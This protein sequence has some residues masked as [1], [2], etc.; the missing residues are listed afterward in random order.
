M[1]FKYIPE[2]IVRLGHS[3]QRNSFGYEYRGS[4]TLSINIISSPNGW[5]LQ[6]FAE[7][8]VKAVADLGGTVQISE[9][10]DS[11]KDI[12]HYFLP[13]LEGMADER[14]T[15]M[16]THVFHE[17]YFRQIK[18]LTD[19]GAVGICMSRETRDKLVFWGLPQSK[20][21]YVNPAQD[22]QIKPAKIR[23]G[24]TNRTYHDNRKRD[25][26]LVDIC[27]C[28]DSRVFRFIIMGSGWDEIVGQI[29]QKGFEVDYYPDFDKKKYNEIMP[30]LD[31]YCYFGFDE[32]AMGFLDAQ[33]AGIKTIVT[34]Q[35]YHLDSLIPITYS[36]RTIYDIVNVL[37]EI[38]RPVLDAMAFSERWTWKNYALKHM[39]I[40]SYLTGTITLDELFSNRGWYEDGIYSLM[41][42][43]MSSKK[44]FSEKLS[45]RQN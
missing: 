43:S 32:G 14:T 10:F 25:A 36:V 27:D 16:I 20:I 9:H 2:K 1:N 45:G 37:N 38:S 21:C 42:N 17:Q 28:I 15:F 5:I 7:E 18:N 41:V 44:H 8:T 40:W 19:K 39:E 22:Q 26:M 33:A 3:L 30:E 29:R 35:G 13:N 12:N 6:K 24:F 23:L 11:K 31:Y 4:K 34:P